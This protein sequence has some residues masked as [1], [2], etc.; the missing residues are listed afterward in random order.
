MGNIKYILEPALIVRRGV[1]VLG[2]SSFGV[3]HTV[4]YSAVH[5]GAKSLANSQ[6]PRY[7]TLAPSFGA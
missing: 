2:A 4:R 7:G 3:L 5:Q 6:V 1:F